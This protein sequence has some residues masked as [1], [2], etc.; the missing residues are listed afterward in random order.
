[1]KKFYKKNFFTKQKN[2]LPATGNISVLLAEELHGERK[3]KR[4]YSIQFDI[5]DTEAVQPVW[6]GKEFVL[7]AEHRTNTCHTKELLLG[8]CWHHTTVE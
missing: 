3:E 2:F 8:V 1:M 4:N 6:T 5:Q 7:C